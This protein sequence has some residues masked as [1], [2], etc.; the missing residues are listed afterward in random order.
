[1]ADRPASSL[2]HRRVAGQNEGVVRACA[3]RVQLEGE[4]GRIV[5]GSEVALFTG[6]SSG[7]L[8]QVQPG[9]D[10][11]RDLVWGFGGRS[12]TTEDV[13]ARIAAAA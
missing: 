9:G 7:F 6:L 2:E 1:M 12:T 10:E 4:L 13:K 5:P 11:L 3:Q 8:Q